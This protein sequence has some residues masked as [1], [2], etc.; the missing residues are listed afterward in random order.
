MRE[1]DLPQSDSQA[2]SEGE[3]LFDKGIIKNTTGRLDM[4]RCGIIGTGIIAR[5]HAE[6]IEKTP[7]ATL[8]AICDVKPEAMDAFLSDMQIE[9]TSVACFTDY[10]ELIL[11]KKVDAI[12][13][14]T[15]TKSHCEIACFA[16]RKSV[17]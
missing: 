1:N 12:Y 15:P 16:D 14:C 2:A 17:V 7:D 11:S 10:K 5:A 6:G 13:I 8:S 4:V 9:K 3:I